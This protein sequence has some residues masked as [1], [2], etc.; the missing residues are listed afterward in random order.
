MQLIGKRISIFQ[1]EDVFSV[2]IM[3]TDKKWKTGLLFIW[4]FAWTL[5]G[6][7]VFANYFTLTDEKAKIIVICYMAF[8]I[9]FEYKIGRAF[10]FRRF[11][12]EKLWIKKGK[13]FYRREV[14]KKG[15]IKEYDVELI[16]DMEVLQP[17]RGNFF[18]QMQ[19]SFWVIG[20]ERLGFTYGA[21]QVLFGIQLEDQDAE[22]LYK[23]LKKFW[24]KF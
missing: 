2:V 18:V 4:L 17:N 16:N 24:K 10:M 15:K 6:V 20:G 22:K 3:P 19:E 11:G 7:L 5:C 14:N 1:K 23:E 9:Y 13:L 8:W 21:K 12:K